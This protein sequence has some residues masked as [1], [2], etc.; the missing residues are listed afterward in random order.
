MSRDRSGLYLWAS[1]VLCWASA[2]AAVFVGAS[3][4]VKLVVKANE[5]RGFLGSLARIDGLNYQEVAEQGYSYQDGVASSVAFFPAFPVAA[6]WLSR[7]TGMDTVLSMVLISNTCCFASFVLMGVYL[8]RRHAWPDGLDPRDHRGPHADFGASPSDTYAL[9]AMALLPTTVFF[10]LAYTESMF[11]CIALLALYAM[12]RRWPPIA[13]ALIVGLATAVRPVAVALLL[14]LFWYVRKSSGTKWHT[15]RHLAY[16]IPLACWGLAAYMLFQYV[17]FG[18]PFAFA[19]TQKYHRMR[20]VGTASEQILALLSWEPIRDTYDPRSPGYWQALHYSPSRLLSLEFANPIYLV[21]FAAL[22]VLGAWK[23]WLTTYEVLLAVPLLAISY[24]TRAYEMRML[25][26]ARFAAV[27][28][29]AYI[30][31]G[32]LLARMPLAVAASLLALSGLL[33]GLYAALFAAGYP[34]L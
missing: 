19:L 34:F 14:P 11:L 25:S 7:M 3:F 9:L 2:T 22:I 30:V 32:Q 13:V 20:P 10:R 15:I 27:V 26:Q 23:R 16:V 4:G 29:P 17:K 6:R 12:V 33:L 28:F 1:W 21:G 24:F 5:P 18:E 31:L 8:Q